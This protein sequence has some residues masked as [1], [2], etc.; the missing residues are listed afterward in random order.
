MHVKMEDDFLTYDALVA[1][2]STGKKDPAEHLNFVVAFLM[3]GWYSIVLGA[4]MSMGFKYL[5]PDTPD[6]HAILHTVAWAL[7]SGLGIA[8][9]TTLAKTHHIFVGIGS[10]TVSVG[11]W[12]ALLY[13][14]RRDFD[15]V[16]SASIFGFT[17]SLGTYLIILAALVCVAGLFGAYLGAQARTNEEYQDL[18]GMLLPIA[19]FHWLWLWLPCMAWLAMVPVV[20]YYFWLQIAATLY[21]TVHPSLWFQIGFDFFWGFLGLMALVFGIL[22]SLRAVSDRH[23]YGGAVWKRT[24]VFLAGT[25]ILAGVISPLFLNIDIAQLKGIPAS[26]GAHPWW[27]L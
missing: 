14:V 24:L 18:R 20:A 3:G 5:H 6:A 23:S 26:L 4:A 10:T 1:E 25:L 9:A 17:L 21:A 8:L 12:L 7:G 13:A 11:V 27:L 2:D 19:S 15:D 16:V 22:I